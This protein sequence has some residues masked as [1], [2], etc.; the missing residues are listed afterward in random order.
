[1]AKSKKT[2][3]DVAGNEFPAGQV[4]RN[5]TS[6]KPHPIRTFRVD[7]VSASVW[8]KTITKVSTFTVYSISF[9]RH[10]EAHGEDKY[11]AYFNPGD[12]SKIVSLCQQAEQYIIELQ[13]KEIA[14]QPEQVPPPVQ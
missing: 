5:V 1:M 10:Y 14:T 11:S 8:A 7:N 13:R 6:P 12:L 3:T 9:Q 2:D 4:T